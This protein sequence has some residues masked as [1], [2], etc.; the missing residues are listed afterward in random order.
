MCVSFSP[1]TNMNVIFS[2]SLV[3]MFLHRLGSEAHENAGTAGEPPYGYW[4]VGGTLER[5]QDSLSSAA[6]TRV[7]AELLF[8]SSHSVTCKIAL[9]KVGHQI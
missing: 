1:D 7:K 3:I 8:T 9:T 4:R 5:K 2:I 6:S